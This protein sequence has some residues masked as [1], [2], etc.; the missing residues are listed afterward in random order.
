MSEASFLLVI[1]KNV[2]K[3]VD[4]DDKIYLHVFF[5]YKNEM[6]Y[7]KQ[8][9]MVVTYVGGQYPFQMMPVSDELKSRQTFQIKLN[10]FHDMF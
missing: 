4:N 6:I 2:L 3:F 9:G 10:F 5:V 8:N 1:V 7:A